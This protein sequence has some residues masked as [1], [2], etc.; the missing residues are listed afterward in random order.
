VS[1]RAAHQLLLVSQSDMG[2]EVAVQC[3]ALRCGA[4]RAKKHRQTNAVGSSCVW[5]GL[6]T[7]GE[8][9]S[10]THNGFLG[11]VQRRGEER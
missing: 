6:Q 8:K 5:A 4:V 1:P 3:V 7:M 10:T 2:L 11:L 9:E